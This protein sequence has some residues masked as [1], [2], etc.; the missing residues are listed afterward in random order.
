MVQRTPPTCLAIFSSSTVFLSNIN[1][2]S[3]FKNLGILVNSR[4]LVDSIDFKGVGDI[5]SNTTTAF[6]QWMH[7]S[8]EDSKQKDHLDQR[9]II[10]IVPL[11]CC[12]DSPLFLYLITWSSDSRFSLTRLQHPGMSLCFVA[13]SCSWQLFLMT[14]VPDDSCWQL[15]PGGGCSQAWGDLGR[16]G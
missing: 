10:L 11:T 12:K 4:Q 7:C 15:S 13:D 3:I 8:I 5:N 16:E 6:G 1:I 14:A 2:S 9:E